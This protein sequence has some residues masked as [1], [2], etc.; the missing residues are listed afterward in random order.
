MT[1]EGRMEKW[2][3]R[4]VDTGESKKGGEE[5]K[6]KGGE[7]DKKDKRGEW[8]PREEVKSLARGGR[9]EVKREKKKGGEE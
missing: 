2:V 3:L 4:R 5:D 9:E 1:E 6:N 8:R 7:G